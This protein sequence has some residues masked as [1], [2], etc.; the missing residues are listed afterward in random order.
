MYSTSKP[1]YTD[2]LL[3]NNQFSWTRRIYPKAFW[4]CFPVLVASRDV[5]VSEKWSLD[6]CL[7]PIDKNNGTEKDYGCASLTAGAIHGLERQQH[8]IIWTCHDAGE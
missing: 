2:E 4:K 1:I 7:D 6:N 3:N 5:Y 8:I